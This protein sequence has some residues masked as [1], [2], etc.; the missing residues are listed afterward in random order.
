MADKNMPNPVPEQQP[1]V[2]AQA[3]VQEAGP[4]EE[5]TVLLPWDK[6]HNIC[7]FLQD[8]LYG[9]PMF[10]DIIGYLRRS[11]IYKAISTDTVIHQSIIRA[12]WDTARYVEGENQIEA[13]IQ[14]KRVVVDVGVIRDV[15]GFRDMIDDRCEF[16]RRLNFI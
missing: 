7:A 4:V 15:L 11:R 2:E 3:Q 14:G 8:N 16:D 10:G 5:A 6:N 12:F 13:T 1:E 9:T